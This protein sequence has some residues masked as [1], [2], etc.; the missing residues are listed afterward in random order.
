[1]EKAVCNSMVWRHSILSKS[2]A[3]KI[4]Q[5]QKYIYRNQKKVFY[6]CTIHYRIVITDATM[7]KQLLYFMSKLVWDNLS[8]YLY[9]IFVSVIK[10]LIGIW[11]RAPPKR[12]NVKLT[13]S[14]MIN[15]VEKKRLHC[16]NILFF[17]LSKHW[18]T[19]AV[20]LYFDETVSLSYE[21]CQ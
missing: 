13:G 1:M 15:R 12:H 18:K 5:I 17:F 14:E 3:L 10:Q 6:H 2:S 20:I 7:C 8:I 21:N 9:L 11:V 4:I 19:A 16:R